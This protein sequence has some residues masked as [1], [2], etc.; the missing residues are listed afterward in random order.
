MSKARKLSF[1]TVMVAG[2]T[3]LAACSNGTS[4]GT[5]TSAS[6][7]TSGAAVPETLKAG[8]LKVASCLDYKPFEYYKGQTLTGFDVDMTTAIA[9]KLGLQEE[10]VKANYDTIF[11]AD[12]ANQYDMVAAA[13]TIT[14][15]REQVV[16]FS[17]PYYPSLQG[18]TVN[19]TKTPDITTTDALTSSDSVAVQKGTTGQ[20]W[21]ED[22]LGTKGVQVRTFDLAP[23]MFTALEAGQVTGIIND[24]PS[25]AAEVESRPDLKVVQQIDT[26]ENYGFAF[27]KKNPSLLAAVNQALADLIADGTYA[28]I[29]T[30]YFPGV[31]VPAQFQR[32]A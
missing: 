29:F 20:S 11:T 16:N 14:K 24:A 19:T 3:L 5:A 1:L 25:S 12:A 10:W 4:S 23:D 15:E 17:D 7:P 32:T 31:E 6:A 30:K 22:N 27:S 9:G 8:T 18:F 26:N 2:V 13:S 21:A 28:Q